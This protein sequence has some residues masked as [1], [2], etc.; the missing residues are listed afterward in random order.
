LSS[1]QVVSVACGVPPFPEHWHVLL[2]Q[3][4]PFEP[5]GSP[6]QSLSAQS[7]CP[8]Q[9]LSWLS[10]QLDSVACGVPPFPEHWH[11]LLEQTMPFEPQGSPLQS[12]SAQ[13]V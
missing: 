1:L 3:T 9:S 8:S 12:L 11:V 2:E 5:Q 10:P 13:S 4:M 7:V 6:L